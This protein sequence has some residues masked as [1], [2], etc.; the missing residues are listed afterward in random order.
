MHFLS[1]NIKAMELAHIK[2]RIHEARGM[3]AMLDKDLARI[4]EVETRVL[5]QAVRRN[6]DRFPSNFM[7]EISQ[8]EWGV[9]RSQF[10][11]LEIGRGKHSK[12][13]PFIH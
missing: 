2:N 11:T 6:I 10:V 7:F 4:Y 9:L 5:K 3:K 12:Y 13:L 8:E 1:I